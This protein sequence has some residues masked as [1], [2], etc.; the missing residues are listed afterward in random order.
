MTGVQ[1]EVLD[2]RAKNG[3][4]VILFLFVCWSE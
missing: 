3:V 4:V 2:V 1:M